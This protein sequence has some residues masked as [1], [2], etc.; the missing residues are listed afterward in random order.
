MNT[1]EKTER[2]HKQIKGKW[3][4]KIYN[5]TIARIDP[6]SEYFPLFACFSFFAVTPVYPRI[7]NHMI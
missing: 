6:T 4:A 7:R 2:V 5:T 1:R 3:D